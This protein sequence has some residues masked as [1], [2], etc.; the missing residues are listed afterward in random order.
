MV[1]LKDLLIAQLHLSLETNVQTT[2]TQVKQQHSLIAA[3]K[4]ATS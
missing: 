1:V 3:H 4:V 2:G